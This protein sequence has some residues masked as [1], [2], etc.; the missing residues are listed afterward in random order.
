MADDSNNKF[1]GEF[2]V[3]WIETIHM[4][5]LT[6]N[7]IDLTL[8][9]GNDSIELL[10]NT[11]TSMADCLDGLEDS[12]EK[13]TYGMGK[14]FNESDALTN[15]YA[16]KEKIN[17]AI[18]GLQFYDRLTQR[19]KYIRESL[20]VLAELI[21]DPSRQSIP[22]EWI[23]LRQKIKSNYSTEQKQ[24][25]FNALMDGMDINK[26]FELFED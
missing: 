15:C 10:T 21:D 19:F 20:I 24:T 6:V 1:P 13:M 12:L 22:E 4:L 18:I 16:A 26:V 8:S 2:K 5:D 3:Q 17:N 9:E 25:I 11:F 23:A 14:S 7:Q